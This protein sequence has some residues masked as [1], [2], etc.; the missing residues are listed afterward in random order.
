[1]FIKVLLVGEG[2]KHIVLFSIFCCWSRKKLLNNIN[3]DACNKEMD[4]QQGYLLGGKKNDICV[5]LFYENVL[6]E[7]D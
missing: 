3:G 6:Q 7:N 1:M 2:N 5:K 4:A